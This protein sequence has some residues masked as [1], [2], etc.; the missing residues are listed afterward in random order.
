MAILTH[1]LR[2]D[3]QAILLLCAGFGQSRHE[4]SPLSPLSL[5]EYNLLAQKL[6]QQSLRPANLLSPEGKDWVSKEVKEILNPQRI[7]SLLER[8]AMLALAVEGWTNKGLWILSRS[9]EAYPQRLK[10]KLKHLSPPI[11]YGVG[12]PALLALGGLAI[13]GSRDIDDEG[14]AYTQRVVQK[15]VEQGIQIVSGGARGVDQTA[16]LASTAVGGTA[17]GV[18]ADSLIKAAV[19]KKYRQGLCAGRIALVS[20]FD[21]SAGFNVGN[22]MSRNKSIYA[23]ADRG[24]IVNSGEAQGGTWAGAKEELKQENQIPVWVR[25]QGEVSPGNHQLVKLGAKPFP[26]EP[27]SCNL[28]SL[29]AEVEQ[30]DKIAI[31]KNYPQQLSFENVNKS[32]SNQESNRILKLPK[33]AYEA[34]LPLILHHLYELKEDQEI[35]KLLDVAVGQARVWLKR[36]V[37][38]NLVEKKK[39]SYML[40]RNSQQLTLLNS[41]TTSK[42]LP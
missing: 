42:A 13:V 9:D 25:V 34:V 7:I 6:K 1:V 22:A 24:L 28:L 39:T 11:L 35:A 30:L 2:P 27:W 38:E 18:L 31:Q 17:V 21:P 23:L 29:L 8:G 16:I 12:N 20:P 14:L 36:A 4:P 3:T 19:A 40:N 33:D 26:S 10:Q 37:Q 32:S 41:L 5:G 15:S